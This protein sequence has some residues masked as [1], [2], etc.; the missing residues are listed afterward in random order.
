MET[1]KSSR[2]DI[3]IHATYCLSLA[4]ISIYFDFRKNQAITDIMEVINEFH[5]FH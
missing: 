5:R 4:K 2:E 3:K 1:G